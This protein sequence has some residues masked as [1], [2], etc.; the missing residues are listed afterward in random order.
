MDEKTKIQIYLIV[1]LIIRID[2]ICTFF[3]MRYILDG[4]EF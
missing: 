2:L 4:L 3:L 1:L